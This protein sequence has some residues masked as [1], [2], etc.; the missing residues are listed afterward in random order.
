MDLN[1]LRVSVLGG[2]GRMGKAI[3]ALLAEHPRLILASSIEEADNSEAAIAAADVAIDFTV[4]EATPR[5]V[6]QAAEKHVPIVVGTTG[7]NAQQEAVLAEA[8]RVIPVLYAANMSIGVTL[9]AALVERAAAALGPE[10]DLEILEMHH[11]HK[12]DAPSGTALLLGRAA[13]KGRGVALD[14]VRR[15]SAAGARPSGSIGFAS[16][17][18]GDVAGDHTVMFAGEGERLEL[19]HRASSRTV[20]AAGALRAAEWLVRQ[21]KPGLYAMKDVLGL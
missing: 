14:D 17:R 8:A 2:Q 1:Q 13:A 12:V 18:G 3:I 15:D 4:A 16:L 11:R 7:L 9:L 20:F 21:K 5:H 6:W 19:T 10:Y